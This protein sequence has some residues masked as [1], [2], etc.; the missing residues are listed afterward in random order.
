VKI[1][2]LVLNVDIL[3]KHSENDWRTLQAFRLQNKEY[4]IMFCFAAACLSITMSKI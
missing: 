2:S 1:V 3:G 4:Y